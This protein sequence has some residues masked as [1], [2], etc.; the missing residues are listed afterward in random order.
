[1]EC[2]LLSIKMVCVSGFWGEWVGG[3]GGEGGGWGQSQSRT[4]MNG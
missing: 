1:M 3:G 4:T 2:M